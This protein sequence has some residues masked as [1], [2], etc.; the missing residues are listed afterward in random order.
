M[1]KHKMHDTFWTHL[2]HWYILVPL[3]FWCC[4]I[5]Q[6]Y[7]QYYYIVLDYTFFLRKSGLI[8][9]KKNRRSTLGHNW[10]CRKVYFMNVIIVTTNILFKLWQ[11]VSLVSI[12]NQP[13]WQARLI[14][15]IH[16]A[17]HM[18]KINLSPFFTIG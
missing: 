13:I 10:I 3:E 8:F 5:L 6:Y 12:F 7:G 15:S 1:K 14:F 11:N 9:Q 18:K 17:E 16:W 4:W 2:V